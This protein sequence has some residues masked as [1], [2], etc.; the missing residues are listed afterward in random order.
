MLVWAINR[1]FTSVLKFPSQ[2]GS[3]A[4]EGH[5]SRV[6]DFLFISSDLLQPSSRHLAR[7]SSSSLG[8][9]IGKVVC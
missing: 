4:P 5:C 9:R 3:C 7:H 6:R 1:A 8:I 2:V